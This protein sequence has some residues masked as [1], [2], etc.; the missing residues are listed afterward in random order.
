M[1]QYND[2]Q[3]ILQSHNFVGGAGT[4]KIPNSGNDVRAEVL[5]DGNDV[6][7]FHYMT[8]SSLSELNSLGYYDTPT[9][10]IDSNPSTND[11]EYNELPTGNNPSLSSSQ[12][13]AL[14]SI[15]NSS[16]FG[17]S[18]SDVA[19]INFN[20][21]NA[22][23]ADIVLGATTSGS[24]ILN[25][26][27]AYELEYS[28]NQSLIDFETKHGD[29]WIN[30]DA[31]HFWN[32]T[33]IGALGYWGM[34]HE[35]GHALGLDH[36]VKPYTILGIPIPLIDDVPKLGADGQSLDNQKYSI[37][38]YKPM[39]GMN[40]GPNA[41]LVTPLGLQLLDIAAIQKLYGINWATRNEDQ[42]FSDGDSDLTG[43]NYSKTTAF[44]S[45]RPN[46]AFIYT[47]WDGGGSTDTI[48]ATGYADGVQIDL[49]EG[50]F[51]SIGKNGTTS[52][53][54]WDGNYINPTGYDAGNVAIAYG[55]VIENAVGTAFDDEFFGNDAD[56][57][58][59]G[60]AG[61]DVLE[62]GNGFDTAD[63][64]DHASAIVVEFTAFGLGDGFVIDGTN[65][66]DSLDSIEG[67]IGTDHDDTFTL[68]HYAQA[69]FIDGGAGNDH[70]ILDFLGH[71]MGV[72]IE[73]NGDIKTAN[74]D[75]ITN[76]ES[77]EI[78]LG[79]YIAET[80][81]HDYWGSF[82]THSVRVN[83]SLQNSGIVANL[84]TGQ[85]TNANGTDIIHTTKDN[86]DDVGIGITGTDFNDLVIASPGDSIGIRYLDL[87]LGNDTL[88]GS[89]ID[90]YKFSGG[91]DVI[92][93][94]SV[95]NNADIQI[96]VPDNVSVGDI[97]IDFTYKSTIYTPPFTLLDGGQKIYV[98]DLKL[99]I[100][101]FGSI[102]VKDVE[103]FEDFPEGGGITTYTVESLHG[104]RIL[105]FI[106]SIAE[107]QKYKYE[108]SG[109]F[110]N[111]NSMSAAPLGT[112]EESYYYNYTEIGDNTFLGTTE[113]YL[114]YGGFGND[115]F[116]GGAGNDQF[117]G[118]S[119]DDTFTYDI[120]QNIGNTDYYFAGSGTDTL[121]LKLTAA[122]YAADRLRLDEYQIQLA[123]NA[124][125][126]RV[127][128]DMVFF[129]YGLHASDFEIVEIYID[130]VLGTPVFLAGDDGDNSLV[131]GAENNSIYAYAGNDT[132]LGGGGDDVLVG[133][134]GNDI[135]NGGAG[136]D[137]VSYQ[138]ST[139]GVAVDL[140]LGQGTDGGGGIDTLVDVENAAGSSFD[141]VLIGTSGENMLW[142]YA[143]DDIL[144]G[145]AGVDRLYG[146]AGNDTL[147]YNVS[148]N[149]SN[150]DYFYAGTGTDTLAIYLT[151]AEYSV[152]QTELDTYQT[153]L[154]TYA[155]PNSDD[156][157]ITTS[158]GVV[159]SD[160]EEIDVYVDGVLQI[161]Y[162]IIIGTAGNDTL[163]GTVNDDDINGLAGD[164]IINAGDGDD[165]IVGGNG[166][167]T[168]NGGAGVDSLS[169]GAG[170]DTFI[171]NV[172]ENIGN[173]DYFY[174]GTGT[175]TLK[176]Y[177][178][179]AEYS[180]YQTELDAYQTYLDTYADSNSD[181][182]SVTTS[183][184]VVLSDF[185][186]MDVYVDGVLQVP[187]TVINGTSGNDNLY[188]TYGVDIISGLA[189]NDKLY[190]YEGDDQLDGG[191]GND[192]IRGQD[193][194]DIIWGGA[195]NDIIHGGDG[196]NTM[197]GGTGRDTFYITVGS[198]NT[199][200]GGA[201][202]AVDQVR[203]NWFNQTVN[204]DL[205]AGTADHNGDGSIDD[206]L[207]G[208]EGVYGST[209][210]D[211]ILGN[212]SANTLLGNSGDD[213][214]DG[215]SGADT[216]SGHNGN[217]II[218]GGSSNDVLSGGNGDDI[219]NGGSGADII[220]G[221]AGADTFVFTFDSAF[222]GSDVIRDFSAAEGD[223]FDLTDVLKQY[224][225]ATHSIADFV[226]I[227]D[228]GAHS[229]LSVDASGGAD[230]FTQ[231]AQIH[232]VT[233]LASVAALITSGAI[234]V[235]LALQTHA[236][237]AETDVISAD[238]NQSM[239]GNLLV[240]NGN[241]LDSDPDG[242]TLSVVLETVSSL[243]GGTVVILANGNF[244]YTPASNFVGN[245]SFNYTLSDS[246][247]NTNV[248]LV[249]VAVSGVVNGTSGNDTLTG[250]I[251]ND[252]LNGLAGNDKLY[253]LAGDDT[254]VGGD[255]HDK[256]FG[257]EGDDI[258]IGG[259][260]NN[261]Y[262]G[263]SG[264][265]TMTGISG[266][267]Y[268]RIE[269]GSTNNIDGGIGGTDTVSY[270]YF[271]SSIL[272][273]MAAGTTDSNGNSMVDDT[274]VSIERIIGSTA[275]DTILGSSSNDRLDGHLGDDY[276]DG[277][278]GADTLYGKNGNDI[279]IGG[280]GNDYLKG[281]NN[282]DILYGGDGLDQLV[283]DA[284]AD[285]FVFENS[286]AFNDVDLLR[287]FDI[288]E[289]DKI[290]VSDL[291]SAYDPLNDIL[292]DFVQITDDGTDSFLAIDADGGADNFIQ[293][294]KLIS[295]TGL[296]D[297]I[298]LEASGNL[299]IL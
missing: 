149:I 42:G 113:D 281:G 50:H 25:S 213:Y 161:F 241:G 111:L 166:D 88:T 268:F 71:N 289:G 117:A 242:D 91:N 297:E 60:G 232:N 252:V 53:V 194:N 167:D 292:T 154:D 190:G 180:V 226:Q 169:G 238:E 51:S 92:D 170:N 64:K 70:V 278:A 119:G 126:L 222:T 135:I 239:T 235:P 263:G 14:S 179:A 287:D 28:H 125:P 68:R 275:N 86:G 2:Y 118:G 6:Y 150:I 240:D 199:I 174:A 186:E 26:H 31:S 249:N 147:V 52:R 228:D 152:Y 212:S 201:G 288:S 171:Y 276:L 77:S 49:R 76:V 104:L 219:L 27:G 184:G 261:Q 193:G 13:T 73:S 72:I 151:A 262:Y 256:L 162:N 58:F 243:Q 20:V 207:V 136:V 83:Y 146:G 259:T 35:F 107:V 96:T 7:Q 229:Y 254:L 182:L 65:D 185:E 157:S 127:S 163:V 144:T 155:D 266:I 48:D 130:D 74:G 192:T 32:N 78:E 209:A 196:H 258:L 176:I 43:T 100:G 280:T 227:T 124:D 273:D 128:G 102:T 177:L 55:T 269:V 279:L 245:D 18:F 132:L 282:D 5:K 62:A 204:V 129:D 233:G 17:A 234:I 16:T 123:E 173:V 24:G 105:S 291:L 116:V 205:T 260:G 203:Y 9:N 247:G 106:D 148:D 37:M 134:L 115:T 250:T 191:D 67:I 84:S 295:N 189:G 120:S 251:G 12:L 187:V 214:I 19:N 80:M 22:N 59:W 164:D 97:G 45:T 57:V 112:T 1:A 223:K 21:G 272:V 277:A 264:H 56:N 46:D 109:I 202:G 10:D 299:I 198:T 274:F 69:S 298:A 255:G 11:R 138:T 139:S 195:G 41:D 141:D 231:I 66:E 286:S 79:Y 183:S 114:F 142:G 90:Y 168:L 237:L 208:I 271:S 293:I 159:L 225:P 47:I 108:M 29:I 101:S 172:S 178:T 285:I 131:G 257:A 63:Y 145:G 75:V 248:G 284:G 181:G 98:Y 283:G 95:G 23:T 38:S 110:S 30:Q 40:P 197:N 137:T 15:L 165:I 210:N 39:V 121:I 188:G 296:T 153:Y 236:P 246:N 160:F 36:T 253:G 143:G 3:Y 270:T 89:G 44:A 33:D 122:E 81:G 93:V 220:F 85:I 211:I 94:G 216:L 4:I 140:S 103:V 82:E 206:T 156:L 61:A 34:Q 8:L 158:S 133:G 99:T 267:D 290:D 294:S 87:G 175:D 230:H 215:K 54:V 265:N 200:D 244:T 217:D 218:Y 221:N 224:D